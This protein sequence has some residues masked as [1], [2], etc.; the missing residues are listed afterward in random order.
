M[1]EKPVNI[2]FDEDFTKDVQKFPSEAQ[3]KL[4]DLLVIAQNNIFNPLLHTKRLKSPLNK[5]FGFRIARDYRVGFQFITENM[6]KLLT[7][8]NRDKIY[9]RLERKI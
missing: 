6:I 7:A 4:A 8:D 3:R 1:Y 9:R 5:F 2:T